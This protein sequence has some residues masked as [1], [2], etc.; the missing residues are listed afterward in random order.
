M[1]VKGGMSQ[2]KSGSERT[3]TPVDPLYPAM[4]GAVRLGQKFRGELCYT[5]IDGTD[6]GQVLDLLKAVPEATLQEVV[7]RVCI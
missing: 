6:A 1:L 7:Q 4:L 3:G 2:A 5:P